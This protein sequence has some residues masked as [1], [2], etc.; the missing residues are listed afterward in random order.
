M[1]FRWQLLSGYAVVLAV[2]IAIAIAVF[3]NVGALIENQRWVDHTYEVIRVAEGIGAA[4]VDQ[5]TGVRAYMVTG[6]ELFLEP[7]FG[8]RE[9]FAE[10]I[11][12]A[13]ELTSDNPAQVARWEQIEQRAITWDS[14][15]VARYR[16]VRES[17]NAGTAEMSAVVDIVSLGLG[18]EYMDGIRALVAEAVAVE[19]ELIVSRTAASARSAAL[20]TWG[21]LI[22]AGI[23]VLLG[24][25]VATL[26]I[27]RTSSQLGQEPR[28]LEVIAERIA[29]GD[30]SFRAEE[31]K[32]TGVY[33]SMIKMISSLSGIVADIRASAD[34]VAEGSR[35]MSETAQ[36]MSEGATEQAA[37][38]EEVSSSMEEMSSNIRQN[39]DNAMQTDKISQKSA[40]DADEGGEAVTE[41]VAAMKEIAEKISIIEEIA[42]NTNLLALNAAIEAARAGEAGKGFAVVASEVRKLAERSQGAAGE[43]SELSSRSVAIAE[44]AGSMLSQI[45]PDIK[46]TAELVQEISAASN[47]QNS[48]ADQ[49][50]SAI[51]QLDSVIQRNASASEQ[52]ASMAEELNGQSVQLKNAVDFFTLTGRRD[53]AHRGSSS[54]VTQ[55]TPP[56]QRAAALPA[57]SKNSARPTTGR[58]HTEPAVGTTKPD[59]VAAPRPRRT[60]AAKA[61]VESAIPGD[62]GNKGKTGGAPAPEVPMPTGLA[63]V[64]E[65]EV[66]ITLDLDQSG[67]DD[68][69]SE[70]E[71]F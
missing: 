37:N 57:A 23:A 29:G 6:D 46:R 49:I 7:Y 11:A 32:T 9:T 17:V 54:S 70:F 36:Q 24:I 35:Q 33:R 45:V 27:R 20:T 71:E 65:D 4:M 56:K 21:T 8:G 69:D 51:V 60:V 15:V 42:R 2:T 1:K 38:A 53:A 12:Q 16:E 5:E 48:G 31:E 59:S 28:L 30:L 43:I 39:T 44:K 61:P 18:K 13:K 66:G 50:N 58:S 41:T 47:E 40:R 55:D 14:E 22:A 10:L 68:L 62:N 26:I 25:V 19:E 52:M 67:R 63:L 64:D 34:N 3:F